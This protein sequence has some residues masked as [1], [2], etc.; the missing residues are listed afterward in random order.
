VELGTY[1]EVVHGV[2]VAPGLAVVQ[3]IEPDVVV[4]PGSPEPAEF[5]VVLDGCEA[6]RRV[7]VIRAVR[8]AT[9]LGL[10]EAREA[11][12]TCPPGGQ[13]AAAPARGRPGAG[14]PGAGRCHGLGPALRGIA[15]CNGLP[16]CGDARPRFRRDRPVSSV[17]STWATRQGQSRCV[18]RQ[19]RPP[20]SSARGPSRRLRKVVWST[21]PSSYRPCRTTNRGGEV[22]H[23]AGLI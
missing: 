8:E 3:P 21:N 15:V 19:A 22:K 13:G 2:R 7:A 17:A 4:Q 5:D 6:A 14:T 20:S 9:G 12:D 11:V 10:K 16:G 23:E 18:T 1:L